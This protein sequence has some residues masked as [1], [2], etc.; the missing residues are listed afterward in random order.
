MLAAT[1]LPRTRRRRTRQPGRKHAAG[2]GCGLRRAGCR[3][4]SRRPGLRSRP[5]DTPPHAATAPGYGA[6]NPPHLPANQNADEHPRQAS[7]NARGGVTTISMVLV[8]CPLPVEPGSV[9]FSPPGDRLVE[10]RTQHPGQTHANPPSR[11]RVLHPEHS[12][13]PLRRRPGPPGAQLRD[14][15]QRAGL[16]PRGS[17]LARPTCQVLPPGLPGYQRYCPY[18]LNPRADGTYTAPRPELAR[19]LVAASHTQGMHIRVLTD[20]D[21]RRPNTS[22]P[23]SGRSA[24][25]RPVPQALTLRIRPS[26]AAVLNP[27]WGGP[28]PTQ[29]V[30]NGSHFRGSAEHQWHQWPLS[31]P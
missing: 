25:T 1:M 26:A 6:P 21:F 22:S 18:T 5:A 23:Y 29:K 7:S 4:R 31:G 8:G 11:D 17:D 20:P 13:A 15:S 3:S 9:A 12:H 2:P 28:K 10:I 14:R 24:T 19:R 16:A 27:A 30:T